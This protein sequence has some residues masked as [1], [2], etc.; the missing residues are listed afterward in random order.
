MTDKR[1]AI[2]REAAR[3]GGTITKR[4]ACALIGEGYY[5]NADTHVGAVL[6]RMV[7]AGLLN[8]IKPGVFEIGTGKKAKP[9]EIIKNANQTLLEL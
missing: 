3:N 5:C 2:L 6:S 8:R 1:S 9:K 4:D 7:K